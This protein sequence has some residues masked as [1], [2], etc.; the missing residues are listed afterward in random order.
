VRDE[1]ATQVKVGADDWPKYRYGCTCTR[2]MNFEN[3]EE[4]RYRSVPSGIVGRIPSCLVLD[5]GLETPA[6]EGSNTANVS[7]T[8]IAA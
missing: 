8:A 4:N 2:Y 3:A 5:D 6:R 1:D 7:T